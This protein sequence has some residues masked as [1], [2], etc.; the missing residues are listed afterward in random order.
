MI[1]ITQLSAKPLA[2]FDDWT[3]YEVTNVISFF[4]GQPSESGKA[5]EQH[6]AFGNAR[7]SRGNAV[8]ELVM[9]RAVVRERRP[10]AA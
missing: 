7:P 1:L 5:P 9:Q 4:F 3:G 2:A 6:H 8:R 10:A